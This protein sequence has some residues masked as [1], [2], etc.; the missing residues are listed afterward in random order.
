MNKLKPGANIEI[1]QKKYRVTRARD[2]QRRCMICMQHNKCLPCVNP[3]PTV[4]NPTVWTNADCHDKLPIDCY[5]FP[6]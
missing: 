3:D 5:L 6:L 4:D 1:G 2:A